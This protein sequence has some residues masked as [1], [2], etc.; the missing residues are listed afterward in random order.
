MIL[1]TRKVRAM[2]EIQKS[3]PAS[4]EVLAKADMSVLDNAT[5]IAKELVTYVRRS[6]LKPAKIG[7]SEHLLIEHW[8]TVAEFFGVAPRPYDAEPVEIGGVHGFKAKA[9]LLNV[10]GVVVGGAE[11]Y[12]MRDEPNWKAKPTFQLASMAQ[13]RAAAKAMRIRLGWVVVLAGYS[14]TP[15][16]EMEGVHKPAVRPKRRPDPVGTAFVSE[17][18]KMASAPTTDW[19]DDKAA[20]S[21]ITAAFK[22]RGITSEQAVAIVA[23]RREV[24]G[25]GS[26]ESMTPDARQALHE[27]ISHGSYDTGY[28]DPAMGAEAPVTV[29]PTDKEVDEEMADVPF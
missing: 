3:E 1:L 18:K 15:A 14:A 2:G 7:P 5:H 21:A 23:G 25:A 11:A 10:D 12:C 24:V 4:I 19:A 17:A 29:P 27:D 16:E 22:G 8:S 26:F 28:D 13:T 6:E 20:R 9:D